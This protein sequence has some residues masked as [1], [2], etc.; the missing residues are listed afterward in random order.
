MYKKYQIEEMGFFS[1]ALKGLANFA[2]KG[3]SWVVKRVRDVA[4]SIIRWLINCVE[5]IVI[6]WLKTKKYAINNADNPRN[7]GSAAAIK[8]ERYEAGRF[9]DLNFNNLSRYDQRELDDI[10]LD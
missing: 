1:W 6:S 3:I 4:G 10:D 8:K 2:I 9:Y 7:F 5:P